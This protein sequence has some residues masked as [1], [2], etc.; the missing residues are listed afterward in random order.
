[1]TLHTKISFLKSGLRGIGYGMLALWVPASVLADAGLGAV[2]ADRRSGR[3]CRM[4]I[5]KIKKWL[6]YKWHH[7]VGDLTQNTTEKNMS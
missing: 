6:T 2:R 3:V 7:G 5:L 1:M 4:K